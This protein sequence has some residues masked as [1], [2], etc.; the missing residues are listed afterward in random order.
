MEHH[1]SPAVSIHS[2][3]DDAKTRGEAWAKHV[4]AKNAWHRLILTLDGGGIRGYSELLILQELMI[5]IV[6]L[7]KKLYGQDIDINEVLPCHYFDY[8]WG[9]STG[10]LIALMLGRLRMSVPQALDI[11]RTLGNSIFG[12]T[13]RKNVGGLN[14]FATKFKHYKLM[15]AV[16]E[17]TQKYC[18]IHSNCSGDD[19]LLWPDNSDRDVDNCWNICQSVCITARSAQGNSQAQP[20]RSYEYEHPGVLLSPDPYAGVQDLDLTI[21]EA[22]RA[23]SAA[24]F[25]F[26]MF[27][28]VDQNGKA[29]RYKDG[30]VL[31]N[32]PAEIARNEVMDRYA[33]PHRVLPAVLLSIGTGVRKNTPFAELNEQQLAGKIRRDISFPKA[34]WRKLKTSFTENKALFKHVLVRYTEGEAI[35][36]NLRQSVANDHTWYRRL[37][38]DEG[39]GEMKLG[40]WR[41]GSWYNPLTREH[42]RHS[43]GTTLTKLET[44]TKRYLDRKYV[45]NEHGIEWNLLPSEHLDQIAERL[46]HHRAERRKLVTTD[47]DRKKWH[48][49]QGRWATGKRMDPW[50]DKSFDKPLVRPPPQANAS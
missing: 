30:G 4:N 47:D 45:R 42:E 38:V 24:P 46:V 6:A 31:L 13:R 28:K 39:L 1:H 29:R 12:S 19:T 16:R 17:I 35:H 10:G 44:A 18:K 25:Y 9:T 3:R 11:Y 34:L 37:N 48:T 5:R 33:T 15:E 20:L 22:A 14:P 26:K 21:W 2:K 23:T 36:R 8:I 49:H 27:E 40:E 7:E 43:G 32:N 41:A 50:N